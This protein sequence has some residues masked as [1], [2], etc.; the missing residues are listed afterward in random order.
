MEWAQREKK[1]EIEEKRGE[2]IKKRE[3]RKK[4]GEREKRSKGEFI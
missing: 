4:R 3:G 1:R 2:V